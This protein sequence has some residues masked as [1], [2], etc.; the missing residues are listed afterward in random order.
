MTNNRL[1]T[2]IKKAFEQYGQ[3]I[4]EL[5]PERYL[6]AYKL[7]YRYDA[8]KTMHQPENKI[9]LKHARR[10]FT[11]EELLIFQL[12]IQT[13]RRQKRESMPG[14]SHQYRSEEHTSELQ[15]R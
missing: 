2:L 9:A 5:F 7:P 4:E 13:L 6:T 10:R 11:Y 14:Y 3:N 8:L 12:K 15:S 1:K